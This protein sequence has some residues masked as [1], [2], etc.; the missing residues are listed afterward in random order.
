MSIVWRKVKRM[1]L[2]GTVLSVFAAGTV[3]VSAAGLRDIFDGE[4]Y[5]DN[6]PDLKEAFG[7]DEER[8]YRHFLEFGLEEGR[9]M[10]PV[11]DVVAYRAAYNDLDEA[12]GDDWN[13]YV[14]HFVTCGVY[15]PNRREGVLFDPIAYAAAYADITKAFGDDIMAII[16]HYETF[17]MQEN[18]TA[19]TA[20]GYVSIAAREQAEEARRAAASANANRIEVM[21]GPGSVTW[22]NEYDES[23]R[24]I[25]SAL[26]G[27]DEDLWG[28]EFYEYND[29]GKRIK[30]T[31][32]NREGAVFYVWEYDE[33]GELVNTTYY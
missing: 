25:K 12:F 14:N 1:F 11:L 33:N 5:A 27:P 15:E 13:A 10:N 3:M 18:R 28:T 6:N 31:G 9:Q 20:A 17:G 29:N 23:G 32:Y 26:Y 21:V 30:T 4:Y 16:G 24:M 19:G 22:I 7:Y 8:L 2:V